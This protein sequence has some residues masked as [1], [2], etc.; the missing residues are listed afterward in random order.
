MTIFSAGLALPANAQGAQEGMSRWTY[1][2]N[3]WGAK[4]KVKPRPVAAVL[5]HSVA[6]GAMPHANAFL[7]VDPSMLKATPPAPQAQQQTQIAIN[8]PHVQAAPFRNDFGAPIDE[9]K[10]QSKPM[11]QL[12]MPV[13]KPMSPSRGSNESVSGHLRRPVH[14][15][16]QIAHAAPLPQIQ[17]YGAGNGYV[18]GAF[19][20]G[21][22]TGSRVDTGV[23]GR[24]ISKGH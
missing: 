16:A 23:N 4:G 15:N 11:A 18:P 6:P 8:V 21:T 3:V 20:A 17:S 22:G 19:G 5:P 2:P 24:I 9:S 7:G 10:A 1:A 14:S 12:P 13:A